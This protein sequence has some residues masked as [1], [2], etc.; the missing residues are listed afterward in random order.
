[1]ITF[2]ICSYFQSWAQ[3]PLSFE[4][5]D[6]RWSVDQPNSVYFSFYKRQL[7]VRHAIFSN[8]KRHRC[9]KSYFEFLNIKAFKVLILC[10]SSVKV[11][12]A[13]SICVP[14]SEQKNQWIALIVIL[15]QTNN[16]QRLV[17]S[18][19]RAKST[20]YFLK[21]TCP[22]LPINSILKVWQAGAKIPA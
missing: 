18:I 22:A 16:F 15:L 11:V 6:V 8:Q 3:L 19:Q 1:M 21:V 12:Q 5:S 2:V 10:P 9:F 7:K 20:G 17:R 13:L 4:I 14:V